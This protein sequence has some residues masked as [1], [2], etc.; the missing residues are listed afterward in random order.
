MTVFPESYLVIT[1]RGMSEHVYREWTSPSAHTLCHT[2]FLHGGRGAVM[3]SEKPKEIFSISFPFQGAENIVVKCQPNPLDNVSYGKC[4]NT[5]YWLF[6]YWRFCKCFG[7]KCPKS[8]KVWKVGMEAITSFL[9][10][11]IFS[12]LR[13]SSKPP[14]AGVGDCCTTLK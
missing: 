14:R 3:L 8:D 11:G 9:P 13:P 4:C 7:N 5:F 6:S 1:K 10:G 2:P 12:L